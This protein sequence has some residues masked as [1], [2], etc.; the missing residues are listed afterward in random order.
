M[1]IKEEENCYPGA[2]LALAEL[3]LFGDA[4]DKGMGT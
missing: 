1:I 4:V 3:G 2:R